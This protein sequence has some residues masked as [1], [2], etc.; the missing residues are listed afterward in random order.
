[1]PSS[2]VLIVNHVLCL[3][4]LCQKL[5]HYIQLLCTS[6]MAACHLVLFVNKV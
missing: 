5:V 2:L 3:V 6:G 4:V 1:M